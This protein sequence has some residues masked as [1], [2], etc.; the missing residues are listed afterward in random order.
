MVN[1]NIYYKARNAV[2]MYDGN[3]PQAISEQL[4]SV[5]YSDARAGVLGNKYYISMKDGNNNWRLFNYDTKYGV[6]YREDSTRALGFGAAEDELYFIDEENNTLVSVRGTMG[7]IEDD[8]DWAA[9]FDLYGVNYITGG[10]SDSPARVR[11]AK[12][13]SMFKI[14]MYLDPDAHMKLWIKYDD[15]SLYELM[16]ERH[17]NQVRTFVLPVVPKR[18]DHVRFKLTGHGDAVVYSISRIMEVGGDG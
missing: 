10:S 9:V 13:V 11:N 15:N 6:W 1:E 14:R 16:G 12:Y 8:F 2:M 4:G 7:T 3:M 5:L 18:C 17:G